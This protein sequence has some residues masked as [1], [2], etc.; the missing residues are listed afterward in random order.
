MIL[1]L[2]ALPGATASAQSR[3]S[4]FFGNSLLRSKLNPAFAPKTGYA[5]LP[6][7]GSFSADGVSNVGLQHFIFPQGDANELFL[8]DAVPA[9]TFLSQL[10][11]RDPYLQE[12]VESDLFGFGMKMGRD[13]YATLSLSVVGDGRLVLSNDLLRFAKAGSSAVQGIFEGGSAELSGYAALSAG[14]SHDLGALA[15]GLRAGVRVKLLS[16]LGAGRFAIDRI[17]L[18]SGPEELSATLHGTGVTAGIVFQQEGKVSLTRPGLHGNGAAIDIGVSYS[19]PVEGPLPLSGIELSGSVC[20]LGGLR[21]SQDVSS[22]LLDHQFAFSGIDDFTGDNKAKF[23]QMAN[24]LAAFTRVDSSE[25]E[26][27]YHRLP[28]SV[29]LGATARLWRDK[30]NAGLLYYHAAGHHNLMAAGGI[31]PFEWLNLGV[32]WTFLGPAARLGFHAE[33]VPKKYLGLFLG[34]ERASLYGNS[35]HIPI[36]NFTE[37]IAF[38]VNVLFGE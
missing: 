26:P 4:W 7:A 23:E 20:D 31:S 12:R 13:G 6:G 21:Y 38:G 37:S 9:E 22:L 36:R 33:F 24:D 2:V 19:L 14:Y 29:H 1:L 27:F 32:N 10:P 3:G 5:S 18:Q 25:G 35:S 16:A 34:M 28:A 15:E 11:S 8:S 30:A 17:G